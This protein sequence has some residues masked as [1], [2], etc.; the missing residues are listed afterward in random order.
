MKKLFTLIAAAILTMSCGSD[1][2]AQTNA[3]V[4]GTW[5]LTAFELEE[6]V[7]FND[8][9]TASTDL[10]AETGCY[11]NSTIVFND[12]NGIATFS[13]QELDIEINLVVGTENTYEYTINCDPAMAEVATYTV[14]GN[15][16]TVT[17]DYGDGETEDTV[18]VRSGNT[19][20]V[21]IPEIVYVP[22]ENSGDVSYTFLGATLQFTKQ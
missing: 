1:D 11:N 4:N 20:T 12:N 10:I 21:T 7:D 6:A 14:N 2:D 16:V 18:F 15:N 8:D 5:K 9:G 3:S 17:F 19:L 22:E 13:I